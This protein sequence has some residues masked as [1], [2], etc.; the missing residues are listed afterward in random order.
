MLHPGFLI[1]LEFKM[2][3]KTVLSAAIALMMVAGQ[4]AFAQ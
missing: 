4:P 1:H 2:I 3:R